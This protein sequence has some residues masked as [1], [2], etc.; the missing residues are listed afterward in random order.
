MSEHW[1][2]PEGGKV[3]VAIPA[4]DFQTTRDE[5]ESLFGRR[6][7]TYSYCLVYERRPYFIVFFATETD[8]DL[9]KLTFD[10]EPYDPRD[11]GGGSKWMMW[12]KGRAAKRD[13]NRSPY[14]HR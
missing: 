14:D 7:S 10:A 5:V 3:S 9:A 11:K 1:Q 13:R 6:L 2:E 4:R 8:A 12:L